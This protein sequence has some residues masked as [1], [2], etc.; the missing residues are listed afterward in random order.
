MRFNQSTRRALGALVIAS[1]F[2]GACSSS[3]SGDAQAFCDYLQDRQQQAERSLYASTTS[4]FLDV[5]AEQNASDSE[6]LELAPTEIR[7]AFE[8]EITGSAA[9]SELV[10]SYVVENNVQSASDIRSYLQ[11]SSQG[12]FDELLGQ[13]GSWEAQVAANE[14]I[15]LWYS[16]NCE[17][18]S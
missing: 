1:A 18:A 10:R 3:A 13:P 7:S 5:L 11:Q 14:R 8:I 16:N 17:S 15:T 12:A 6:G 4:E 2:L 9:I